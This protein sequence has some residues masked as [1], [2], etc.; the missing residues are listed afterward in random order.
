MS[1]QLSGINLGVVHPRIFQWYKWRTLLRDPP[2]IPLASFRPTVSMPSTQDS[3]R[4]SSKEF[5][6]CIEATHCRL[7]FGGL[8]TWVKLS[9]VATREASRQGL[10]CRP[11]VG[12]NVPVVL[13]PSIARKLSCTWKLL[14]IDHGL[15]RYHVD[16]WRSL[17]IIL[18]VVTSI[19]WPG[20]QVT[21]KV[22]ETFQV[23]FRWLK[24]P[25]KHPDLQIGKPSKGSRFRKRCL[26]KHP[27]D[28][29]Q[30]KQECLLQANLFAIC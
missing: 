6:T 4:R 11:L 20:G 1:F 22:F 18:L 9:A 29:K 2:E 14:V 24:V 7:L 30:R 17:K 28:L 8:Y 23:S 15:H 21:P 26:Q 19:P 27:K 16:L 12:C 10:V 25:K 5:W 13:A 3:K